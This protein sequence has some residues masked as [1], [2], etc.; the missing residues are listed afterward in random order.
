MI[1]SHLCFLQEFYLKCAAHPTCDNDTSAALDLMMP[2]T[3]RVP[4]IACTDVIVL[5]HVIWLECFHLYCVTRLNERQTPHQSLT[6]CISL[7][8]PLSC[9]CTHSFVLLQFSSFRF[10]FH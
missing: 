1:T 10:L 3:C 7:Y 6:R 8:L 4:C 2:N 5:L 9:L